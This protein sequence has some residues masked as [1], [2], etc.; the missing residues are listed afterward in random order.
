MALDFFTTKRA[1]SCCELY[2]SQTSYLPARPTPH[3]TTR[4]SKALP[5]QQLPVRNHLLPRPLR[6]QDIRTQPISISSGPS[7]GS[8]HHCINPIFD[9][10]PS[11]RCRAN[12]SFNLRPVRYFF[13][14]LSYNCADISP[15]RQANRP[16]NPSR[17]QGLLRKRTNLPIMAE[18]GCGHWS[19][20]HWHAE[21][22]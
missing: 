9:R 17:A 19:S 14:M 2:F 5:C 7:L 12:L 11:G 3:E 13:S 18:L 20:R 22:R 8:H 16:P 15:P 1:C 4:H 6:I 10:N 21:L